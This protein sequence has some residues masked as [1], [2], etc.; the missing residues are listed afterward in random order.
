MRRVLFAC[1]LALPG[2]A[3]AQAPAAPAPPPRDTTPPGAVFGVTEYQLARQKL[4]QVM[5]K[6]GFSVYIIG[7]MEGLAGVV[8]N[9]TEM[10]P[11]YRGGNEAEHQRFREELT[12]EVNAVIAGARAAGATEAVKR[13]KKGEF[14]PLVLDKP[15]HVQFK[16]RRS[17][18]DSVVTQVA[19]LTEFKLD[20]VGDRT[21]TLTTNSAREM[22][23]LLDAVEEIVI[24]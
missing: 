24:R 20:K 12:A 5:Q 3:A 16:L 17:F 15:Y 9:G 7:D 19:G 8:R 10:R 2:A 1:L 11:G 13:A 21:F 23:W 6:D 4:E 14:K 18:A 22:G